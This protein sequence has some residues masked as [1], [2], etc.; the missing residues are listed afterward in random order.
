MCKFNK[1]KPVE[2]AADFYQEYNIKELLE[3]I[4]GILKHNVLKPIYNS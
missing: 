2:V 3:R 1:F 4:M